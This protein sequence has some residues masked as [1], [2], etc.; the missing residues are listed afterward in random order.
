MIISVVIPTYNY[1]HYLP[2]AIES[3]L[4]QKRFPDEIIVV[5]DGSTDDTKEVVARYAPRVRYFFQQNAGLS[6]ARNT[7]TKLASGDWV[8]YL[9]SDD[10]WKPEKL[11]DQEA[12]VNKVPGAV[13]AYT[14]QVN[15]NPD[16]S[17]S[18]GNLAMPPD[19]IWPTLRARNMLPASSVMAHRASVLE[20]GGFNEKLRSC[21]DWDLWVRLRSRGPFAAAS[22]S[23]T[24]VRLTPQSMS[25]NAQRMIDNMEAI[26]E[27]TLLRGL[28]GLSRAFWRRRIRSVAQLHAAITVGALSRSG[29]RKHLFRSIRYWPIPWYE[30]KR[31]LVLLRNLLGPSAWK[32]LSSLLSPSSRAT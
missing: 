7:G 27:G 23:L 9:D 12:A 6:A 31:Y 20:A 8:A 32:R 5:D 14:G 15:L 26:L 24:I 19:R 21:E 30:P 25:S 10:A 16:G 18:E 17:I 29:E 1:G 4:A 28:S 3:V 11:L 2:F 13:V 22:E